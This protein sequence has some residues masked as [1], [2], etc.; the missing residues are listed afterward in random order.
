[1]IKINWPT[2]N[3]KLIKL[4]NNLKENYLLNN[5]IYNKKFQINKK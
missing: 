4:F 1:M 3:F 5:P 2:I